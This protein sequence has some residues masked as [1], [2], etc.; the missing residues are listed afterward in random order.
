MMGFSG[1]K[2]RCFCFHKIGDE[3]AT[4]LVTRLA[5]RLRTSRI[6]AK[7]VQVS[8]QETLAYEGVFMV[9]FN[10]TSAFRHQPSAFVRALSLSAILPLNRGT[11][12]VSPSQ[13]SDFLHL[14][15]DQR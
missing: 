6:G 11:E 13:T 9:L 15:R 5:G 12:G 7:D 8:G 14:R 4:A 10:K 1:S 3:G 2:N